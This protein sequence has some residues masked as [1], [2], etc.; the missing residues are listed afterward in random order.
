MLQKMS[1]YL[2]SQGSEKIMI[3]VFGYNEKAIKFYQ[4]NGFHV[5]MLDMIENEQII[6]EGED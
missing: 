2:K 3:A 4:N 5:R 6:K 1:N